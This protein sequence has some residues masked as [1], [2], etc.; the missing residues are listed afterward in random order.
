MPNHELTKE[1]KFHIQT[2]EEVYRWDKVFI[3]LDDLETRLTAI[4]SK[5]K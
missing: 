4:E 5:T 2:Q 1:E 3:I